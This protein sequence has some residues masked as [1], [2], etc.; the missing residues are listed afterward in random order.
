[1][2]VDVASAKVGACAL[3][4]LTF[5]AP[6]HGIDMT[7]YLRSQ[8]TLART[9]AYYQFRRDFTTAN[10]YYWGAGS[11]L[12]A[13]WARVRHMAPTDDFHTDLGLTQELYAKPLGR[14]T[15]TYLD[16]LV[17]SKRWH[18]LLTLVI[19]SSAFERYLTSAATLAIASDPA[20]TPGF[21]KR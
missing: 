4:H 21:P 6:S 5:Q 12:Q 8:S 10:N 11:A 2:W 7:G 14:T 19:M 13:V 15:R 17:V 16:K 20:L 3:S 18:R 1:M 9:L